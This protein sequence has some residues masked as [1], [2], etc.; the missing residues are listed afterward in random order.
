MALPKPCCSG[1]AINTRTGEVCKAEFKTRGPCDT[2]RCA[3]SMTDTNPGLVPVY[4]RAKDAY[5]VLPFSWDRNA[6]TEDYYKIVEKMPAEKALVSF[7][8]APECESTDFVQRNKDA[9]KLLTFETPEKYFAEK[10][11]LFFNKKCEKESF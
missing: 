10:K 6:F 9:L 8:E 7:S 11:P 4:D 1:V 3:Q 2:L 5:V